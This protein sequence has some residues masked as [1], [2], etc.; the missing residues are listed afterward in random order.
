[1]QA[2]DKEIAGVKV[3]YYDNDFFSTLADVRRV[4]TDVVFKLACQI[5]CS[6]A[7]FPPHIFES[8]DFIYCVYAF[9]S[10]LLEAFLLE[11][12]VAVIEY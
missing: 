3:C 4:S 5:Q 2:G 7:S 6:V 1:V 11:A 9:Y 12:A 10:N 8:R